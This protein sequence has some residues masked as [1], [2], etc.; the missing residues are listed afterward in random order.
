MTY[1]DFFERKNDGDLHL[2][3]NLRADSAEDAIKAWVEMFGD[4]YGKIVALP[5]HFHTKHVAFTE[6]HRG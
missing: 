1:W 3:G 5:I 2:V 4:N 6:A